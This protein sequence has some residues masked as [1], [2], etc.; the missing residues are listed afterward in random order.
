MTI[1]MTVV[2][3]GIIALVAQGH[4][5]SV[6]PKHKLSTIVFAAIFW[7]MYVGDEIG[8]Y[9]RKLYPY[10]NTMDRH[11]PDYDESAD[12]S[13]KENKWTP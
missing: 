13:A 10:G 5:L 7:P 6:Y 9:Q 11:H 1:K 12:E 4:G 8:R 3:W 2:L